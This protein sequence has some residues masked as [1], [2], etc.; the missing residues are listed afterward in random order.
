MC[1]PR[2]DGPRRLD[3]GGPRQAEIGS[4]LTSSTAN[5]QIEVPAGSQ[6]RVW[7]TSTARSRGELAD[8]RECR[9]CRGRDISAA[10]GGA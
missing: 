9:P 10:V 1:T 2:R 8:H 4:G 5:G 7:T 6:L 3:A